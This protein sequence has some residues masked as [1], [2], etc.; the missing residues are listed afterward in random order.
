[1][2]IFS[3]FIIEA[4]K[5]TR[6]IVIHCFTLLFVHRQIKLDCK[7]LEEHG[8]MGYSL[9]LGIHLESLQQGSYL[10]SS[11]SIVSFFPLTISAMQFFIIY[12]KH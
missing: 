9:L 8:I 3:I 2:L 6:G 11:S 5:I 7:F 4:K 10:N 12:F 1:M